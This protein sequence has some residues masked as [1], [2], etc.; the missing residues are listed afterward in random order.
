[1]KVYAL[2]ETLDDSFATWVDVGPNSPIGRMFAD[3]TV[4]RIC[5]E[6][7]ADGQILKGAKLTIYERSSP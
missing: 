4:E 6:R 2:T 5:I 1:M 7:N 3:P